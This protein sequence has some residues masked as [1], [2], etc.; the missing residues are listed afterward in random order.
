MFHGFSGPNSGTHQLSIASWRAGS[1]TTRHLKAQM[2]WLKTGLSRNLPKSHLQTFCGWGSEK[3]HWVSLKK[4]GTLSDIWGIKSAE[5]WMPLL[6]KVQQC[7]I[8]TVYLKSNPW[9][10][11]Y[12]DPRSFVCIYILS[13]AEW[14]SRLYSR[15]SVRKHLN[16]SWNPMMLARRN[17]EV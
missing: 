3:S 11:I 12:F 9:I 6:K 2:R 17:V 1:C 7:L 10:L 4:V 13:M 8:R 16:C 14:C 5:T 15:R